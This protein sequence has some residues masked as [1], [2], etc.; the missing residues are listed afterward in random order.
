MSR[1]YRYILDDKGEPV[2][3]PDLLPWGQGME[4]GD[5][6]LAVDYVGKVRIST[7]FLGIDHGLSFIGSETA[8]VLWETMI[9]GGEHE[10]YQERYVSRSEA[11]DGHRHAVA[12]VL[13]EQ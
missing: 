13:G 10:S 6:I 1:G 9:F 11:L 2:P 12:L 4:Y 3:E 7:V 8:P 5:R